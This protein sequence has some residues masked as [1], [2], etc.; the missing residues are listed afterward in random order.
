[1][2]PL[3]VNPYVRICKKYVYDLS[4][5]H[6]NE[7]A[8]DIIDRFAPFLSTQKDA[9]KFI[10]LITAV[11]SHGYAKA[12]NDIQEKLQSQNIRLK[13]VPDSKSQAQG[14]K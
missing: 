5:Q 1:M 2:N 12:T 10:A 13:I 14:Q 7:Q 8:D 11:F 3:L 9:E 6:Y 4:P